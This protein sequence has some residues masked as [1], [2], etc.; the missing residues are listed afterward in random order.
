LLGA[1]QSGV[2]KTASQIAER[3]K[4]P[5]VTGISTS[6]QLTE[7]GFKY[8]FRTTQTTAHEAIGAMQ[9]IKGLNARE[10]ANIKTIGMFYENTEFGVASYDAVERATIENGFEMVSNI[11]FPF[12]SVDLES[13]VLLLKNA[14]PDFVFGSFMI[15]D[16]ILF[17]KTCKKL[18][19]IPKGYIS[20]D[21]GLTEP[22]LLDTVAEDANFLM[23]K[24]V[25]ALDLTDKIPLLKKV[26]EMYRNLYGAD[27]DGNNIR[28]FTGIMA[29][30]DAINRAGSKDK[31]AIR[32][33]LVETDISTDQLIV[34][35]N[36]IKFDEKGQNVLSAPIFRQM[37]NK[38]LAIVY[39]FDLAF[40]ELVYPLPK[41]SER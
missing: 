12:S 40:S 13:E 17:I 2:T 36:G 18:D 33:A 14:N 38:E 10:N 20:L 35:W 6:P 39:P 3:Y 22:E 9:L 11:K 31:E 4:T 32:K 1:Y 16:L 34:T 26:N 23:T 41:W 37:L 5:F 29:L 19:Y 30:M 25:F 24:D 27:F 21:T 8:F 28:V 15:S 7:R